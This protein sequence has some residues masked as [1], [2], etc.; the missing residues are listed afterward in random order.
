MDAVSLPACSR[1][2]PIHYAIRSA[3]RQ[4]DADHF[5]ALMIG[6]PI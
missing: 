3:Q 4:D 6:A 5:I 2:I 1:Q